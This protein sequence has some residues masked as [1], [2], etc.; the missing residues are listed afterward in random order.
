VPTQRNLDIGGHPATT[1]VPSGRFT[2]FIAP[3]AAPS[4]DQQRR[5]VQ[6]V[7]TAQYHT[8]VMRHAGF[9]AQPAL[10]R[11]LPLTNAPTSVVL[12]RT[13]SPRTY[14]PGTYQPRTNHGMTFPQPVV[15]HPVVVVPV[16]RY[17]SAL[18]GYRPM[19]IPA[20]H[21]PA[22]RHTTKTAKVKTLET[23]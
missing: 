12:P 1:V 22:Y 2:Q 3:Q 5:Y 23:R 4:F 15:V 11:P 9:A 16:R 20:V 19:A 6:T 17:P 7:T 8:D 13:F 21:V 18:G 14:L 10:V